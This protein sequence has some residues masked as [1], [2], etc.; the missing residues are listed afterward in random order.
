MRQGTR[1][2]PLC[3]GPRAP[4]TW[5]SSRSC[6][7]LAVASHPAPQGWLF[8]RPHQVPD[9]GQAGGSYGHKLGHR[10]SRGGRLALAGL[11]P[12]AGAGGG[13]GPATGCHMV[14]IGCSPALHALMVARAACWTCTAHRSDQAS[15]RCC[16]TCTAHRSG[17][18]SGRC[19]STCPACCWYAARCRCSLPE[20]NRCVGTVSACSSGSLDILSERRTWGQ[21]E[22]W[23]MTGHMHQ[24]CPQG[25]CEHLSASGGVRQ[26]DAGLEPLARWPHLCS[27]LVDAL[28]KHRSGRFWR[29]PE[30]RSGA[31]GTAPAP[32]V[33]PSSAADLQLCRQVEPRKLPATVAW[34]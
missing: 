17:Q 15:G 23:G 34:A 1:F 22:L 16:S 18:A 21:H 12:A 7:T 26:P 30:R 5:A 3:L 27:N 10:T 24:A 19:C 4:G 28:G 29:L 6:S 31:P 32:A 2:H 11:G 13:L 20:A 14:R 25:C 9:M 8:G 33:P